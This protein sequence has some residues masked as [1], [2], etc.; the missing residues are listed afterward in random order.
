VS[1]LATHAPAPA[2]DEFIA[3]WNGV[4]T[5]KWLRFRHLLSGAGQ[6]HSDVALPRFGF[7]A[8]ENVLDIGCGFGESSLEIGRIVGPSGGVVGLDCTRA[9]I[10]VADRERDAAGLSQVRYQVGDAEVHPLP[11]NHFDV[12]FSRFGVM[13]FRSAVAA[14]RNAHRALKPDGRV[15]LV[16]WRTLGDNPAWAAAKK[17]VLEYLP[18]PGDKGQ[19]CGPGPFSWADEETDRQV[20]AAAGFPR[21][22]VLERID[23]DIC[24]G[25]TLEEAVDYQLLV[26]PAGEIVREAHAEGQRRLP[27]IRERLLAMMKANRRADGVYFPSSTWMIVARRGP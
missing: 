20:L 23:R 10:E 8:G 22:D 5:P 3:C 4:L 24:V 21:V 15:C 18:P 25:R 19:T 27:E 26:G 14:L 7:R 11:A 17:L 12:A 2:V 6:T 9:F 1:A 13:F 16:V